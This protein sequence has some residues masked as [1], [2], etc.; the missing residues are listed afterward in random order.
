MLK[1]ANNLIYRH[2]QFQIYGKNET[3]LSALK[4]T[5]L[6]N[7]KMRKCDLGNVVQGLLEW[8]KLQ[9]NA[10]FKLQWLSGDF[11]YSS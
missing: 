1:Y 7:K 10:G 4:T 6:Q 2:L 5:S 8:F 9:M 11:W 3:I